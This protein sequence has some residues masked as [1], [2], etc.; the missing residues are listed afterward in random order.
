MEIRLQ[1][2]Q[3]PEIHD[4]ANEEEEI[5]ASVPVKKNILNCCGWHDRNS[6][7]RFMKLVTWEVH[8]MMAQRK[9]RLEFIN[10]L[11]TVA[12]GQTQQL[13]DVCRNNQRSSGIS[14]QGQVG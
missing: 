3:M 7:N 1:Q 2:Q 12:V 14:I 6:L 10:A 9:G 11:Q 4:A 13:G 5:P 8:Q